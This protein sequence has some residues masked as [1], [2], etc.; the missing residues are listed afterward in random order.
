M[1]LLGCAAG[2][3]AVWDGMGQDSME[4]TGWARIRWEWLGWAPSWRS[5]GLLLAIS[6]TAVCSG[7]LA[8]GG[9]SWEQQH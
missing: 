5:L 8:W 2:E 1:S 4:G 9:F 6:S 3:A 7:P